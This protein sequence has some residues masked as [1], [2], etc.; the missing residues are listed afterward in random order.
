MRKIITT[1]IAACLLIFSLASC[2]KEQPVIE[3]TP[4]QKI[5]GKWMIETVMENDHYSGS[6]HITTENGTSADFMDFHADGMVA[7]SFQGMTDYVDYKFPSATMIVIDGDA[8]EVKT[9]TDNKFV[10]YVKENYGGGD[11]DEFTVT[12]KR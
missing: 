1:T 3:K 11:F 10:M 4:Q 5:V 7:T 6:D 2:K 12:L 9:F 8:F